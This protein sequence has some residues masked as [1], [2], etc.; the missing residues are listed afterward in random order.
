MTTRDIPLVDVISLSQSLCPV[1]IQGDLKYAYEDN[2]IGRAIDGYQYDV[3]D[4]CLL[5]PQ[6]A[7]MLCK[8]QNFLIEQYQQSLVIFDAYRPLRAT[9]DFVKW[10]HETPTSKELIRKNIHYPTLEKNQL[11]TQG[12]IADGISNHC[13]G[14]SVDVSLIDLKTQAEFDMGTCFDFFDSLSHATQSE[15]AIGA[16]AF[17]NRTRLKNAMQRYHFNVHPNEYW[18]F[19]FEVRENLDPLDIVINEKLRGLGV[20]ITELTEEGV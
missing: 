4:I 16:I 10:F 5:A 3:R 11:V 8:V 18:H 13:Y 15:A 17:E 7:K 1:T 12:Y 19:D 2:F 14:Q 9:R 6:A 20:V